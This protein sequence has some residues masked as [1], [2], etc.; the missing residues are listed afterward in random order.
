MPLYQKILLAVVLL[1]AIFLLINYF[2]LSQPQFGKL[3]E[4]KRLER[5]KNSPHYQNGA[6]QN[7][8]ATPAM[9]PDANIFRTLY[10]MYF[11]KDSNRVPSKSFELTKTDLKSLPLSKD[12]LVWMG[13]SSYFLQIEGKRILVDPV[14]SESAGPFSFTVRA[15]PGSSLYGVSDLPTID[16]LVITH[17]HW[18]HLD[19]ETVK[20]IF[21]KV[22]KVI[23][24]LGTGA[25]LE[26]WGLDPQKL[27]ELDWGEEATLKE[28]LRIYGEP[29]R[30]FSGRGLKRNQTLWSSFLLETPNQKIYL[31][32]DSGYGDH[33]K[34]IG[35]KHG[36]IDLAILENGQYNEDWKDI[37]F[38][39]GENLKAM[40]D[41]NAAALLLVHNSRFTLSLHDWDEPMEEMLK[42][43]KENQKIF[44]PEPGA[45]LDWKNDP[46]EQKAWWRSY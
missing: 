13:H 33:F 9:S 26:H 30:H 46:I 10:K 35:K 7:L 32:G 45:V 19:Y 4:G 21:P 23:T 18:D 25:H 12:A 41:L 36:K 11:Q 22:E 2:I 1:T 6:F 28:G 44:F 40:E 42:R 16:Y 20:E 5:I 27:I 37:H 34:E 14:F 39:P 31:G 8:L 3:P 29:A 15:F 38:M 43:K 24:G 17:D